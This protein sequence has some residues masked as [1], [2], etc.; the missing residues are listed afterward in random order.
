MNANEGKLE[1]PIINQELNILLDSN[2]VEAPN[3]YDNGICDIF[4]VPVKDGE[5]KV[6]HYKP[7]K[8]ISVR[9]IIFLP[10]FATTPL[11]WQ[12]FH[13]AHHGKNEY[14]YVE[15]REKESA[16]IRRHRKADLTI[17]Q[18]A[19]DVAQVIDYLGYTD[20]DYILMGNCLC[21][22]VIL[23]GLIQGFISPPTAI[24]FDPFAKWT[25]N[26]LFVKMIMPIFPPFLLGLLKFLIAKIVMANM[27][28]EAQKRRNM[29][30]VDKAVPWKWRKFSLQNVNYDLSH[31]LSKI[32]KE[33]YVCHGPV[34]KYHPEGT[35][36]KVT[37]EIPNGQFIY[38]KTRDEDREFL[39]GIIA[40]EFSKI[41]MKE[42]IPQ[43]LRQFHLDLEKE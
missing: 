30:I 20:Q 15:T 35:F 40:S 22:G 18:L 26:R 9:P 27:K 32:T 7:E 33:V 21:G 39:V 8:Q 42:K 3:F 43:S 11:T 13:I 34:D 4:Y 24:V 10:G 14:F 37:K 25:Q 17:N 31:D 38:M 5:L 6:Y 23:L 19:L 16:N 1:N 12:D 28:N 36:R 41:T 29:D 2:R